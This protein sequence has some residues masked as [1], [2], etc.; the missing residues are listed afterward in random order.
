MPNQK[1]EL[2]TSASGKRTRFI[3]VLLREQGSCAP[4]ALGCIKQ[5]NEL[6]TFNSLRVCYGAHSVYSMKHLEGS[7][8]GLNVIM[9]NET[10]CVFFEPGT[11]VTPLTGAVNLLMDGL[12]ADLTD[13]EIASVGIPAQHVSSL[14]SIKYKNRETV[15]TKIL[16]EA[17]YYAPNFTKVFEYVHDIHVADIRAIEKSFVNKFV[18]ERKETGGKDI[19]RALLGVVLE[20]QYSTLQAAITTAGEAGSTADILAAINASAATRSR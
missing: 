20:K 5:L 12:D 13:E 15:A 2:T 16:A 3:G 7:M 17:T 18:N 4:G 6:S 19:L 14:N 8:L 1:N 10:S 9:L 11:K